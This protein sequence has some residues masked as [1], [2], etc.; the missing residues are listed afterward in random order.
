MNPRIQRGDQR[1]P[2]MSLTIT[3]DRTAGGLFRAEVA[4]QSHLVFEHADLGGLV[5]EL[6]R[7]LDLIAVAPDGRILL[8]EVKGGNDDAEDNAARAQVAKSALRNEQLDELIKRYPV[9]A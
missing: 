3:I 5:E 2:S 9:P 8:A 6:K 4:E 1:G 7:R